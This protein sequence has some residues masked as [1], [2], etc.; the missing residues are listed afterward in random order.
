MVSH[1]QESGPERIPL[2]ADTRQPQRWVRSI[3]V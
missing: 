2:S 3:P 1:G